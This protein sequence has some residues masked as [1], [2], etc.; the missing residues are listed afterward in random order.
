MTCPRRCRTCAL[1]FRFADSLKVRDRNQ[2][3]SIRYQRVACL[4]PIGIVFSTYY[5]EEIAFGEAEFLIIAR[6]RIIV[7]KRFD[8]LEGR[9]TVSQAQSILQYMFD[10][11]LTFFGG[12][13][14]VA[15]LGVI[16]MWWGLTSDL[17]PLTE[18]RNICKA[19]LSD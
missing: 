6:V 7:I 12:T 16:E 17:S 1:S 15:D 3:S 9:A 11:L 2:P 5:V 4:V 10:D 14:A 19:R 13:M 18:R 8:D